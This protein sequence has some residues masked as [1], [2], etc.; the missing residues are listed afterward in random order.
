MYSHQET[1]RAQEQGNG[2]FWISSRQCLTC[3]LQR[4]WELCLENF[5]PP[6]FCK[7]FFLASMQACFSSLNLTNQSHKTLSRI[8]SLFYL[9][10]R[11]QGSGNHLNLY[12]MICPMMS[13]SKHQ[14]LLFLTSLK[15][16]ESIFLL[17]NNFI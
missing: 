16:P 1:D 8:V 10:F 5:F 12:Q 6:F 2:D 11:Y 13:F 14:V 15:K 9:L 7:I 17:L 4:L 3:N